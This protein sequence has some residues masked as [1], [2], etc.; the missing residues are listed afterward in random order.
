M[1]LRPDRLRAHAAVAAELD[2]VLERLGPP[3]GADELHATVTGAR[4]ELAALRDALL[5]AAAGAERADDDAARAVYRA[6]GP[7]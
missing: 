7:A 4:R 6:A 5:A 1:E 3:P 2:A